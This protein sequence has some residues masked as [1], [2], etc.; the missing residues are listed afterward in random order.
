MFNTDTFFLNYSNAG[1]LALPVGKEEQREDVV[2]F[3]IRCFL[4]KAF[5]VQ[6]SILL[7][8]SFDFSR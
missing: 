3:S 6:R 5:S 8:S 1:N 4:I 7:F 2:C